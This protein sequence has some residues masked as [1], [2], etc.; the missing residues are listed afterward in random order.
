MGSQ[1]TAEKALPKSVHVS[2]D[3]LKLR[4]FLKI[5]SGIAEEIEG[6]P[7]AEIIAGLEAIGIKDINTDAVAALLENTDPEKSVVIAKGTPPTRGKDGQV[8]YNFDTS[9]ERKAA[10]DEDSGKMDHRELNLIQNVKEGDT[11]ATGTRPE[12][13]VPGRTVLGVE[14]PAP[15]SKPAKIKYGRGVRIE[16]DGLKAVAAQ[17]GM[18]IFEGGK[19]QVLSIYRI[20]GDVDYETG[21]VLF[22]GDVMVGQHVKE[23]FKVEATGKVEVMGNVDKGDV[24]AGG[25]VEVKG[26]ILGKETVFV[27]SDGDITTG[28][29]DNANLV[30]EGTVL[31]R[32]EMLWSSVLAKKVI[33]EGTKGAVIGGT[34]RATD[35]IRITSSGNPESASK[36]VLEIGPDPEISKRL[37]ERKSELKKVKKEAKEANEVF[38]DYSKI[39][40]RSQ[41]AISEKGETVLRDARAKIH[42]AKER[43]MEVSF[44]IGEMEAVLNETEDG[45]IVISGQAFPGTRIIINGVTIDINETITNATFT[46]KNGKIVAKV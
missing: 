46:K 14:I 32:S 24:K 17:D 38:E 15:V 13:G 26:G 7:L 12:P 37:E 40:E 33:V 35:E 45:K 23:D 9:G 44:E 5:E 19:V 25:S 10:V 31:V 21:N 30:A 27:R 42:S 1:Q 16:D 11:L 43:E 28:F 3:R 22:R 2:F 18:V 39:K 29:A 20:N 36:T 6:D 41:G 34:V 8:Q 4:A